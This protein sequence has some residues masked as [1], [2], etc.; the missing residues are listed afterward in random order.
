MSCPC[1]CGRT[2]SKGHTF[3]ARG[4][5]TRGKPR[6]NQPLT[7]Q[8]RDGGPAKTCRTCPAPLSVKERSTGCTRCVTCRTRNPRIVVK[9]SIPRYLFPKTATVNAPSESWWIGK[10]RAELNAEAATRTFAY[11]KGLRHLGYGG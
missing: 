11:V 4:C 3:A 8:P 5:A 10:S 6:D 2:P 1:G 9:Q 7:V